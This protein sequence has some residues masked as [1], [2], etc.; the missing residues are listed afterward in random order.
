MIR[1]TLQLGLCCTLLAALTANAQKKPNILFIFSDDHAYQAVSAYSGGTLN[2]T[3]H[4]DRLAKEG[5]LFDR[6]YVTNSICGPQRAAIQ[7]GKYSHK[8]GFLRNGNKFD[9]HQQT[10]PKLM[11]KAGYQTAVIGK[12]HL[13]E[14]MAPQ[15][16]DYS[17]VLIGQGPYYN[18]PMLKDTTG[19]GK[20]T[21]VDH[22]GYTS[23]IISE[24]TLDWLKNGRDPDK[25]FM[26]MTQHK[27]PHRNWQPGPDYLT[28]FDDRHMPEP[29][30]LFEDYSTKVQA[31]RDQTMQI[32][33]DLTAYDLKLVP[34][35]NLTPEQLKTWTNAYRPKNNEYL[36]ARLTGVD[37][38]RWKYQRYIKD[39][40]RSIAS[41]DD[42]VGELLT[43][44]DKSGLAD[45]TIVIYTSDQGF[46]LG[47][48]GWFDKRWVYEESLKTP[49]V[50]RWPGSVQAG[51]INK[52][53]V[54]PID[55]AATFLEI[56]GAKVPSDM[57][58]E[59][60]VPI[61][62]GNTPN[63][64]RKTH[65]YH[66]YE[67]PGWHL[68][69]RHYAVVDGRYKLIHFYEDDVDEWELIDLVADPLEQENF[70]DDPAYQDVRSKLEN[71]LK[72][73]RKQYDV[74]AKDPADSFE[75]GAT[76]AQYRPFPG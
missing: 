24:L 74:P 18:P 60:L 5:M 11:Q 40:L 62:K 1:L 4:I 20:S 45:N 61:L 44:L 32:D 10:F 48:H 76:E 13:G 72:R 52:D 56:A 46:Y 35:T 67:Y 33:R 9:G 43:Y 50:V 25:P 55:Y 37:Q 34:P 49:M 39:Y 75:P 21:K 19:V 31:R 70:Y 68:V 47:E 59:S 71:E 53:I 15:G 14:H 8:N 42:A 16:Y 23:D 66:Y 69:R 3:P 26:L 41:V 63:D 29:P 64:W 54:S 51:S 17:E 65:Y 6:C 27:A 12:W 57:D 30:T 36:D 7:T 28:L 38:I 73:L 58:G 22:I 2:Q